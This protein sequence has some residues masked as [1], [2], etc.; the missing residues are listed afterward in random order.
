MDIV[1]ILKE[2]EQNI[3]LVYSLRSVYKYV[4]DYDTVWC[5]GYK[6]KWTSDLLKHIPSDQ[7]PTKTKWENSFRNVIFA[8]NNSQVSENF[9][10][11]NDDFFAINNVNLATDL[12]YC[13]GTLDA[14]INKYSGNIKTRWIKGHKQTKQILE[15][16]GSEHFMDFTLHIPMIINKKKFLE[17][18]DTK[19]MWEKLYKNE[20][21]GYRSIYGN[22]NCKP[23]RGKDVPDRMLGGQWFSV[24]DNVTN[25]F[26][27]YPVA[28]KLLNQFVG[29]I[30]PF[31]KESII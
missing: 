25:N 12:N 5:S 20:V 18:L 26:W 8:C 14:A 4:K 28:H 9:A 23:P 30:S 1:Y 13:R 7:S 22:L 17:L 21:L 15:E 19:F 16:I 29:K 2:D 3:D 27:K 24:F 31:E 6:P 10:L 11:F